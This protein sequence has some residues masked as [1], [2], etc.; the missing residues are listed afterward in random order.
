MDS[1]KDKKRINNIIATLV[2]KLYFHGHHINR[3]EAEE[4]G[5]N[6]IKASSI[7]N[8]DNNLEDLMW[9]LYKDYENDLKL[10]SPY[11]D[12][13][14]TTENIIEIPIK[15]IES[16]IKSNSFVIQQV[17]DKINFPA[18]SYIIK[19]N[20]QIAI[21]NSTNGQVIPVLFTGNPTM[22]NNE[23]YDKKENSFWK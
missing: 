14:P 3:K 20:G 1:K 2:E 4:I 5:L 8:N 12:E 13:L 21:Y 10:K 9:E 17:W 22:I 19:N 15:Y 7:S 11:K 23:I 6:V 18:N 16:E